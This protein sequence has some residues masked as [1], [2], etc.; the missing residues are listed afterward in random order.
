METRQLVGFAGVGSLVIGTF[1]PVINSPLG[2]VSYV[3]QGQGDGIVVLLLTAIAGYFVATEKYQR[4]WIPGILIAATCALTFTLISTRIA[5]AREEAQRELAG[6]P[7]LGLVDAAFN[8]VSFGWGWS[9]LLLG[10]CCLLVAARM[11]GEPLKPVGDLSP[12][13]DVVA[14][15]EREPEWVTKAKEKIEPM[16]PEQ[17]PNPTSQSRTLPPGSRRVF[18]RKFSP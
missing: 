14:S 9:F 8:T 15:I 13:G 7:F 3:A 4:L 5:G 12:L 17:S 18:G 10:L 1:A 16:P 6:N 11:Q 2:S